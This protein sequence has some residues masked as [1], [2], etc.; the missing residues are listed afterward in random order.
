[1]RW[2]EL[3]NKEIINVSTGERLGIFGDCDLEFDV[4]DGIINSVL[5]PELKGYFPFI[6]EKKVKAISWQDIKKIGSDMI[7][8]EK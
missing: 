4:R 7:I 1:M 5:I 6:F 8:I 2:Q 3:K